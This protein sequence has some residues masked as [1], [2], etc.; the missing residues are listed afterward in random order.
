M[1]V[2]LSIGRG[3]FLLGADVAQFGDGAG[4]VVAAMAERLDRA[5]GAVDPEAVAVQA[6]R[7]G[8]GIRHPEPGGARRALLLERGGID[9]DRLA[10]A[11]GAEIEPGGRARRGQ[12]RRTRR[13]RAAAGRVR[14][15][16]R[17]G[18]STWQ[19]SSARREFDADPARPAS[20]APPRPGRAA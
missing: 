2:P 3:R 12:R 20:P 11:G 6:R 18:C 9:G 16:S 19:A 8:G 13:A 14:P 15:R 4:R 7:R 10:R 17:P 5:P 1:T